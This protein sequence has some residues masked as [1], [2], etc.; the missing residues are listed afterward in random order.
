MLLSIKDNYI[1]LN[2]KEILK[3]FKININEKRQARMKFEFI[4]NDISESSLKTNNI[5]RKVTDFDIEACYPRIKINNDNDT[6]TLLSKPSFMNNG[7]KEF[8]FDIVIHYI[9]LPNPLKRIFR[10]VGKEMDKNILFHLEMKPNILKRNIHLYGNIG[11]LN[12][13]EILTTKE[14]VLNVLLNTF[15]KV[16]NNI[17]EEEVKDEKST[18]QN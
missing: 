5:S 7:K 10:I 14:E 11:N 12:I 16:K 17:K 1:L 3:N 4:K 13:D 9:G 8:P 2:G 15:E 6:S 18:E